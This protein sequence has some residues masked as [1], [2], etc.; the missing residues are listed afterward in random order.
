MAAHDEQGGQRFAGPRCGISLATSFGA[1]GKQKEWEAGLWEL[2][3]LSEKSSRKEE[4]FTLVLSF[5][6]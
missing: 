1:E 6:R 4:Q 5:R 3:T 2:F